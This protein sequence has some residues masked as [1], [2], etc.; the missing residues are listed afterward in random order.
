[1]GFVLDSVT[2]PSVHAVL[3]HA[4]RC[5]GCQ[6]HPHGDVYAGYVRDTDLT[7]IGTGALVCYGS[8]KV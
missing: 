7:D 4:D 6:L 2:N 8:N 5:D 3:L 1:M